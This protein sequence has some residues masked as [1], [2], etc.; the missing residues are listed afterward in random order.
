ML[1]TAE[2]KL[3]NEFCV[4]STFWKEAI[5]TDIQYEILQNKPWYD[6][7]IGSTEG[8]TKDKRKNEIIDIY[9]R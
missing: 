5:K 6:K 1:E 3:G 8:A 7:L 9:F 4:I 2:N